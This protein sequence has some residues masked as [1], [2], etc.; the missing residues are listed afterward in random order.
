ML[1][2]VITLTMKTRPEDEYLYAGMGSFA[3]RD[4]VLFHKLFGFKD[5][6]SAESFSPQAQRCKFNKPYPNVHLKLQEVGA[7]LDELS[8][9]QPY[10]VWLDY[11]GKLEGHVFDAVQTVA[12]KAPTGTLLIVTV[13]VNYGPEAADG[14]FLQMLEDQVGSLT[15]ER[16]NLNR[17]DFLGD[18]AAPTIDRIL[19]DFL[20]SSTRNNLNNKEGDPIRP[21]SSLLFRYEDGAEMATAVYFLG[22]SV[23]AERFKRLLVKSS[24]RH[25]IGKK[26]YSI[27][28]PIMTPRE[29]R[30]LEQHLKNMKDA[31]KETGLDKNQLH[32]FKHIA[33]YWPYF[34]EVDL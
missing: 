27:H 25:F 21:Q 13:N 16:L 10:T 8:W 6:F 5:M 32:D 15:F 12:T 33:R 2:D 17:D 34:A 11:D 14:N 9:D 22:A 24:L 26:P 31:L 3:Y 1:A 20:L 29:R 4:F 18:R 19:F 23:E 30:Y 7:M 28:V